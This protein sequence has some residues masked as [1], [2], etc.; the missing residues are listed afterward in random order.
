PDYLSEMHETYQRSLNVR[1]AAVQYP[2]K[3]IQTFKEF[4]AQ[5]EYYVDASSKVRS[6]IV[7]FPEYFTMQLL[8]FLGE[9]VPSKQVRKVEAFTEDYLRV[10]SSMAVRYSINIIAGS[11]FVEENG[12]LY[13]AA[14]LFHRDGRINKQYRLHITPDEQKV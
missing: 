6:D 8:S 5:S 4:V 13:N 11:H 3:P 2:M 12:S 7:V 1:I 10:F 14:F 9:T